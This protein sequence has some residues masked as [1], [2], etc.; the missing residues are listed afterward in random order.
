MYLLFNFPKNGE[1][2]STR[3]QV[4]QSFKNSDVSNM[5]ILLFSIS[6]TSAEI[7]VANGAVSNIILKER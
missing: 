4:S 1:D 3:V 7:T 5:R 6:R 2:A